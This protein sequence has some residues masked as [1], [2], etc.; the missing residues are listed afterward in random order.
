M[1]SDWFSLESLMGG[2]NQLPCHDLSIDIR[3]SRTLAV[4]RVL[5][6]ATSEADRAEIRH[7]MYNTIRRPLSSPTYMHLSGPPVEFRITLYC[8]LTEKRNVQPTSTN[9]ATWLARTGGRYSRGPEMLSSM[10]L[11][12]LLRSGLWRTPGRR[13]SL[14]RGVESFRFGSQA[15]ST[16]S[17]RSTPHASFL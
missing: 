7:M 11:V 17:P 15:L 1:I 12:S 6:I 3:V 4:V 13:R 9:A 8:K 16:T 5:L 2:R 14:F 10:F